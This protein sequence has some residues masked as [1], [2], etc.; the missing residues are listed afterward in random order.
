M[1]A[2]DSSRMTLCNVTSE[3]YGWASN[4]TYN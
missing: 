1:T 3:D 2:S 4:E